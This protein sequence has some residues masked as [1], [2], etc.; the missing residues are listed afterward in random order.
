MMK[1]NTIVLK[2]QNSEADSAVKED[3]SVLAPS[4]NA[5]KGSTRALEEKRRPRRRWHLE[6]QRRNQRI[7]KLP[8]LKL[9]RVH[10]SRLV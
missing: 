1:S 3:S 5:M 7:V 4:L 2:V 6:K 10:G 8:F 9:R